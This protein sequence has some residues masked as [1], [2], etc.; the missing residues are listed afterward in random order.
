MAQFATVATAH[1]VALLIPGVDFFLIARTALAGGWRR[2]TGACL[3]IATANAIF[4]AA[5]FSGIA[6]VSDPSVMTALELAGGGFLVFVGVSFLASPARIDVDADAPAARTTWL[7]N[8][9]LGLTSGLLNPKNA[10]FYLSLAAALS[11]A[12]AGALA[13]YGAWMVAVV[14]VWDVFVAVALGSRPAL[15]RMGRALPWLTRVAG[16][17]LALFGGGMIVTAITGLLA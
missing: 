4:I 1:F 2:A 8:V 5:A 15:E 9:G 6:L 7:R 10:L 17:V 14:L 13:L 11:A 16:I 3:G 12:P